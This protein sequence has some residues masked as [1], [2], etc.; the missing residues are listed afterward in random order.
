MTLL[1]NA[2]NFSEDGFFTQTLAA[3]AS[4]KAI[5]NELVAWYI[6]VFNDQ[7]PGEWG[8]SWT[9]DQVR[10]KLFWATQAEH[11]NATVTSWRTGGVL[12]GATFA[13]YGRSD[14]VLKVSDLPPAKQ[15]PALLAEVLD[16]LDW[17]IGSEA[18]VIHYRE[19]GILRE[20]R[21]GPAPVLKLF[22]DTAD[23]A[24][25]RGVDYGYWW[26]NKHG[27]LF[28]LVVGVGGQIAYDF[29]DERGNVLML[30]SCP[31]T[32]RRLHEPPARIMKM[33]L[34]RLQNLGLKR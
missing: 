7:G 11:H 10:H 1:R 4:D 16:H 2:Q 18:T 13:V 29:H 9:P 25:R 31:Q 6:K 14:Q 23:E 32:V 22:S 24:W 21:Q 15:D 26:T 20:H 5:V 34:A 28:P 17:L 3:A 30:A 27:R 12:A 8:E 33:M 19:L